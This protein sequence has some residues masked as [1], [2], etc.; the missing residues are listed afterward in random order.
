MTFTIEQL[1][2]V[3]ANENSISQDIVNWT[4]IWKNYKSLILFY[5]LLNSVALYNAHKYLIS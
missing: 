4:R 5:N 3:F 1:I 2:N